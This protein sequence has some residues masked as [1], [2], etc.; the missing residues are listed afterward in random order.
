MLLLR[1]LPLMYL[2]FSVDIAVIAI[3]YL[4]LYTHLRDRTFYLLTGSFNRTSL[5]IYLRN[6]HVE[7][8]FVFRHALWIKCGKI[9]TCLQCRLWE[10][11]HP[12]KS[13]FGNF[14]LSTV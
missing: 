8:L 5:S 2:V 1:V 4:F 11:V 12:G 6:I 13:G 14:T 9:E 3:I 7:E 10:I